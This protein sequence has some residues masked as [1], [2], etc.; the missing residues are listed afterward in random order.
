MKRAHPL[1]QSS[2][3]FSDLRSSMLY[4]RVLRSAILT[5]FISL[6]ALSAVGCSKKTLPEIE[7]GGVL[8]DESANTQTI[9]ISMKQHLVVRLHDTSPL[10]V[11]FTDI[12]KAD[13][14]IF[15]YPSTPESVWVE[16]P[17]EAHYAI[18]RFHPLKVSEGTELQFSTHNE[19]NSVLSEKN[20]D[21]TDVYG[22]TYKVVVTE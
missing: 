1:Q 13:K 15:D 9:T 8:L 10:L 17:R 18:F 12:Q 7:E 11:A 2:N 16:S 14:A 4:P 21:G 19:S 20:S 3:P 22:F 5:A 6:T